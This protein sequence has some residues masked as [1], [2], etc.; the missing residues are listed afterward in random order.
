MEKIKKII[1][2]NLD[3]FIVPISFLFLKFFKFLRKRYFKFFPLQKILCDKIGVFPI[4]DH[5]YDPLFQ[6]KNLRYFFNKE[7][8]LIGIDF[9][10]QEQLQIFSKFN[11]NNELIKFPLEKTKNKI[12]YCYNHGSF[13]A[14]DGEL[15]YNMIRLFKPNIFIEVGS[16]YSTLMAANA[17]KENMQ[18]NTV[19]MCE[20]TCIEPYERIWLDKMDFNVMRKKV[21]EVEH[22]FFQKLNNNDIL[23]IDSSHISKPQGDVNYLF[24]EII[25]SLKSGVIVHIHDIFTPQ[26]YPI[27]WIGHYFGNE[28]YILESFLTF[29]KEYKIIAAANYLSNK[30]PEQFASKCPVYSSQRGDVPISLWM[31]PSSFWIVKV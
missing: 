25:P 7:R 9:N 13:R 5:Y 20:H 19:Y 26:D 29:N 16:G 14:G 28:Q 11:Y 27:E 22:D 10:D 21:E 8:N 18:Q 1:F 30:Y 4:I 2:I 3:I 31:R 24:L 23:F 6:K 17:I 12:E 15:L